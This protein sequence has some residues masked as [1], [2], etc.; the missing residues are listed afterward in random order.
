MMVT[1]LGIRIDR[2]PAKLWNAFVARCDIREPGGKVTARRQPEAEK[3]PSEMVVSETG[4]RIECR[5][6]QRRKASV[7]MQESTEPGSKSTN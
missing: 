5:E 2:R 6:E 1:N 7:S 4:N 3:T